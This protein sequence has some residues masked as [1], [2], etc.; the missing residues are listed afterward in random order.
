MK[1]SFLQG[2]D[3]IVFQYQIFERNLFPGSCQLHISNI[4]RFYIHWLFIEFCGEKKIKLRLQTLLLH[5][6]KMAFFR[7]IL[8]K[9]HKDMQANDLNICDKKWVNTLFCHKGPTIIHQ[10]KLETYMINYSKKAVALLDGVFL[11]SNHLFWN[12]D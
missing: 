8:M 5:Q 9:N 12:Q 3:F 10:E 2:N 7:I 1:K 4:N 11:K 6:Q